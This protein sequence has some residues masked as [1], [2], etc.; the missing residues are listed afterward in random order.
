[1][2]DLANIVAA[3]NALK[4]VHSDIKPDNI[5]V[6]APRPLISD[7][8]ACYAYYKHGTPLI[9]VIDFGCA[10]EEGKPAKGGTPE[11]SDL[12][13]DDE[14]GTAKVTSDIFAWGVT[15]MELL[16][17]EPGANAD[18]DATVDVELDALAK[19]GLTG[20]TE[21]L[22]S[23]SHED[24]GRRPSWDSIKNSIKFAL[25]SSFYHSMR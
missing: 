8:A 15:A 22:Y 25:E 1:M 11:Y 7:P 9:G 17:G 5:L 3:I 21:L 19:R 10:V 14:A 13:F 12:D 2:L 24:V 16:C 20:L 6:T 4:V 23:A 18:W